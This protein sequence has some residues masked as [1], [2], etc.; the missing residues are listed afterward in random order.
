MIRPL[1][2]SRRGRVN[3]VPNPVD[4]SSINDGLDPVV[5]RN[6]AH[7]RTCQM[8]LL[9]V[10]RHDNRGAGSSKAESDERAEKCRFH[11]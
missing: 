2:K 6:A 9:C 8:R 1:A 5:I 11:R 7:S 4:G 10:R 3:L